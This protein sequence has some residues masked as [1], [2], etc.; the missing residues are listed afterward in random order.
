[1]SHTRQRNCRE[2][3]GKKD[4]H[5]IAISV[6]GKTSP[7][8]KRIVLVAVVTAVAIVAIVFAYKFYRQMTGEGDNQPGIIFERTDRPS[9]A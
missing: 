1:M 9:R 7:M 3:H 8:L 5:V 6:R 4:T 2:I